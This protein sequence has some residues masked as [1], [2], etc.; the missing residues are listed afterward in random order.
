MWYSSPHRSWWHPLAPGVEPAVGVAFAAGDV[1]AVAAEAFADSAFDL[2][3]GFDVFGE[4]KPDSTFDPH[5]HSSVGRFAAPAGASEL[6]A[7]VAGGSVWPGG[8]V[9]KNA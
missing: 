2:A 1:P 3:A 4:R 6:Q 7:A 8:P 5:W 9:E